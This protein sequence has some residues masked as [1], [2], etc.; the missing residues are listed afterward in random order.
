[1]QTLRSVASSC[2]KNPLGPRRNILASAAPRAARAILLARMAGD[3]PGVSAWRLYKANCKGRLGAGQGRGAACGP[4]RL[5]AV[6]IGEKFCAGDS[7][8]AGRP[9]CI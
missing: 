7:V 3:P 8:H 5:Q 4:G 1:V 6:T 2:D 9:Y